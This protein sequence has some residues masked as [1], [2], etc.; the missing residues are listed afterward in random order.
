M[1]HA[2]ILLAVLLSS[3]SAEK[4]LQRLLD[5][6]P[7]LSRVDTVTV[8]V[9]VAIPGDTVFRPVLLRDTVTIENDRQ[10]VTIVRVPTGHPCDTV[11]IV[12]GVTAIIKPDTVRVVERITVD[13]VVPCPPG[14][15]VAAWWRTVALVLGVVLVAFAYVRRA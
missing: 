8:D 6:N 12:A 10:V 13:R 2:A 7:E 4:R 14:K 9:T 1:K 5:N 11:P 3:C 15:K